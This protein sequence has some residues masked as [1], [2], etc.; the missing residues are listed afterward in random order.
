MNKRLWLVGVVVLL[1]GGGLGVGIAWWT[2]QASRPVAK[3]IE[4]AAAEFK[5]VAEKQMELPAGVSVKFFR[6]V[7]HVSSGAAATAARD[8]LAKHAEKGPLS[9]LYEIFSNKG[10]VLAVGPALA[11]RL[12]R[13]PPEVK[14][15]LNKW[16]EAK[17]LGEA[18]G[19]IVYQVR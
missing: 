11:G 15:L 5:P 12:E 9:D 7:L 3:P 6:A 14:K 16:K 1:I 13:I 2:Q 18:Q 19:M 10:R 4:G 17:L 8:Y